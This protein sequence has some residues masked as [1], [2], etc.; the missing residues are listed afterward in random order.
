[1]RFLPLTDF[2]DSLS[3]KGIVGSSFALM[4]GG[5]LVYEHYSGYA[6][7]EAGRQ[8]G[9]DTLFRLYSMTKVFTNV[10]LMQL[11]EQGK[12]LLSD[13]LA[14]YLPEFAEMQVV[15]VKPNGMVEFV[16]A[17]RQI[18][19]EDIMGMTAG[20]VYAGAEDTASRILTKKLEILAEENPSYTTRDYVKTVAS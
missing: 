7:R 6:D 5:K 4:Q 13:P 20:L 1:M 15:H 14:N 10:A 19:V 3:E 9:P 12:F 17:K 8:V 16:P 11:Y 2:L 18:R